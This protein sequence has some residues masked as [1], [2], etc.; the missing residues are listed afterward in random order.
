VFGICFAYE[1]NDRT[2][3][4]WSYLVDWF[5][6]ASAFEY[7]KPENV[8]GTPY[9]TA[10]DSM[11]D[12]PD[13]PLIVLAPLDGRHIQG[14]TSLHDFDHP[15][16]AI[17]VFGNNHLHMSESPLFSGREYS[18]VYIPTHKSEL[19]AVFAATLTLYDRGAKQWGK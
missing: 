16:D 18:S 4:E 10:I 3:N 15:D 11:A 8:R 5:D 13:Q 6:V 1:N 2:R 19:F 12:L 9:T 14:E 7:G 17:Y